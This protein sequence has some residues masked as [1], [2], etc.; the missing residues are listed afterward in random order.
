MTETGGGP[1]ET[2]AQMRARLAR[3][4]ASLDAH[5]PCETA[6]ASSQRGG[7]AG[8]DSSRAMSAGLRAAS[9]LVGG[10]VVGGFIGWALD[11]WF[12]TKP[13]LSILFFLLGAAGGLWNV[14]RGASR[15][16]SRSGT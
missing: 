6:Q 4:S 3:L 11:S 13:W 15:T 8:G 5:P 16:S 12:G 2:E 1:D 10:I 9:E 14:I 7:A